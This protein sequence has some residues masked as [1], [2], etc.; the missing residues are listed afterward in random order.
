MQHSFTTLAPTVAI[1][2]RKLSIISRRFENGLRLFI[3]T[4]LQLSA[5]EL[6]LAER[7]RFISEHMSII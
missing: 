2:D 1:P 7:D 4:V 5:I 3:V 6:L